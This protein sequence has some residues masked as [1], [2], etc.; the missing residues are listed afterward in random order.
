M[1]PFWIL[2]ASYL[3]YDETSEQDTNELF[4]TFLKLNFASFIDT[5]DTT[6]YSKYD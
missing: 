4:F 3:T 1:S 5:D 2:H 6:I